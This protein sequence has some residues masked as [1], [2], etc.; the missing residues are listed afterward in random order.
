MHARKFKFYYQ[1][2][3]RTGCN[4]IHFVELTLE[5]VLAHTLYYLEIFYVPSHID[6]NKL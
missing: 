1:D 3:G 4:D 2:K 5:Q 6:P